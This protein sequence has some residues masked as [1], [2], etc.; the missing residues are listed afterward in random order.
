MSIIN[1]KKLGNK[2][3]GNIQIPDTFPNV[4]QK[5]H[6]VVGGK[7]TSTEARNEVEMRLLLNLYNKDRQAF[8]T[9][10]NNTWDINLF[11]IYY[12]DGW[13]IDTIT[14]GLDIPSRECM[15]LEDAYDYYN[16][17]SLFLDTCRY[18]VKKI[19]DSG[20]WNLQILPKYVRIAISKDKG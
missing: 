4:Q 3:A 6:F 15:Q 8:I 2:F 14:R 16:Q 5:S 10:S 1:T 19:S 7:G 20:A 13:V 9:F 18:A 17:E 11:H 12:D